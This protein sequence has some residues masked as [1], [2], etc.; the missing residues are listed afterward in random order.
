MVSECEISWLKA[1]L[2]IAVI[3]IFFCW[4]SIK[5]VLNSRYIFWYLLHRCSRWHCFTADRSQGIIGRRQGNDRSCLSGSLDL[6][7]DDPQVSRVTYIQSMQVWYR[8]FPSPIEKM[9]KSELQL[10]HVYDQSYIRVGWPKI[11]LCTY[12]GHFLKQGDNI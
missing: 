7:L 8:L 6:T 4:K 9:L 10:S 5:M 2:Y 1:A 3:Y 12:T 11:A